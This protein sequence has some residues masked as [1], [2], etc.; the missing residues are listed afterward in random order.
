MI[1][2]LLPLIA[3]A[4]PSNL[5][6][7]TTKGWS[8]KRLV[9]PESL[10][11]EV[12]EDSSCAARLRVE[13]SD[14][15]INDGHR[16]ELKDPTLVR[17]GRRVNYTFQL[18]VPSATR[19]AAE[20]LVLAQWHDLKLNGASAQRPPLSVRLEGNRFVFPLFNQAIWEENPKGRGLNLASVP[21]I[22]DRWVLV[23]V[24]ARWAADERGF[25]EI[26]LN[27]ELV[28]SYRG[29]VGYP[30][31]AYAPY[32]KLGVYTVHPLV[33]PAEAYFTNYYGSVF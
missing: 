27:D 19:G 15:K 12:T 22:F 20:R 18:Y 30:A 29:P 3:L 13:T 2:L 32:F 10:R 14:R 5:A 28:A 26:S 9:G 16:A 17:A 33:K 1:S 25:V 21:A 4:A 11:F 24:D 8:T 31:D 23:R 6:D 7:C